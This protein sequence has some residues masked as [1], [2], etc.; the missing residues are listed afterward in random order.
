MI[1]SAALA[2]S[3]ATLLGSPAQAATPDPRPLAVGA[4]WLTGQLVNGVLGGT[5]DQYTCGVTLDAGSALI[6]AGAPASVVNGIGS[7]FDAVAKGYFQPGDI[8]TTGSYSAG[9][10]A[11]TL[12]FGQ[13]LGTPKTTFDGVDLVARLKSLV[14]VAPNIAGRIEDKAVVGGNPDPSGDYANVVGQAFAAAA[15]FTDNPASAEAIS[16]RD[17]LLTQQCDDGFFRLFYKSDENFA[18]DK[19]G[20]QDCQS[21]VAA[22]QSAPDE[23]TT[24]TVIRLLLPQRATPAVGGAITDAKNWLIA[25]QRADGSFGGGQFNPDSNTNSTGVA[26][27]A[28]G[29]LGALGDT[30][31]AAAAAKAAVWV[32]QHQADEVTGCANQLTGATGAIGLNDGAVTTARANGIT[33]PAAAQWQRATAG[34]LASLQYAPAKVGTYK[35][36]DNASGYAKAGSTVKYTVSGVAPGEKVCVSGI[37]AARRVV[38][39][40]SG[41]V[42]VPVVLPAGTANRVLTTRVQSGSSAAVQTDVLGA[43]TLGVVAPAKV[44]RG[45]KVTV[46]VRGLKPAERVRVTY[47]GVKV[48]AGIANPNGVF[49]ARFPVGRKVGKAAVRAY[50][51]FADIRKGSDVLRVVR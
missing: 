34:S 31:A 6:E 13:S 32:R 25:Q 3:G 9:A 23:D 10:T 24:S 1:A 41:S 29:E 33:G 28:L 44:K 35:V 38:A 30:A 17:F 18:P 48:R 19:T 12:A 7:G 50:G 46:T 37:G 16:V 27:W 49:V 2:V 26:G 21:G 22:G 8:T 36:D 11:K 15:L 40:P 45:K 43:R 42:V 5:C 14:S 39:G 4:T 51:Q 20:P 47:K